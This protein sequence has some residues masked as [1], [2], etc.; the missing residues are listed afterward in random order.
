MNIRKIKKEEFELQNDIENLIKEEDL[1]TIVNNIT[2]VTGGLSHRMYKVV[3]DKNIYAIKELNSGIMKR[4]DAYSNFVF[5]EK[6]TDIVKENG[7]TAIGAVKLKNNDIMRKVN[8]RYFMVFNWIEGKTLKAE[9]IKEKHCEIIGEN[10]AKIH[11]IDFKEIEDNDRKCINIEKVNWNKY[12]EFAKRKNKFYAGILERNIDWLYELNEKANEAIKYAKNNLIISHTDLDRKNVMWQEYRPFIIDW[13]ASGY[14]NPTVELIQ[15]AWYWS[16]GDTEKLDYN[17]FEI[18]VNSY[19][20]SAKKEFDRNIEKLI[21][22]DICNKLGWL[23]YN[24]KRSLC[25]ENA[26]KEDEIEI[27]ESEIKKS[28]GEI[29]YNVSKMNKMVEILKK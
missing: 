13:E 4:K 9:E 26:Y 25:I 15:V 3:T 19:R 1:G 28:I 24:L 20:K 2:K 29:E 18:V 16:G 23:N 17:K 6:V 22:A 5:S 8:N 11:N 21:Y 14:I 7:I 12:L 10:L 27:A